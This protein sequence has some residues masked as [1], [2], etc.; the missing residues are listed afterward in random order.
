MARVGMLAEVVVESRSF[1]FHELLTMMG[2]D[3][4]GSLDIGAPI[5]MYPHTPSHWSWWRIDVGLDP[6]LPTWSERLSA[7]IERLDDDLVGRMAIADGLGCEVTL[8]AYQEVSPLDPKSHGLLVSRRAIARLA[9]AAAA[10]DIDQDG[11]PFWAL[12]AASG[13]ALAAGFGRLPARVT[14][15]LRGPA[16]AC[17]AVRS[18]SLGI[19]EITQVAGRAPDVGIDAADR[20]GRWLVAGLPQSL[21]VMDL[22]FDAELHP[23][24]DGLTTAIEQLDSELADRLAGLAARGCW[25]TAYVVQRMDGTDSYSQGI[26]FTHASLMWLARASATI[27]LD[28]R[29]TLPGVSR[30]TRWYHAHG[31]ELRR[32][33]I[34]HVPQAPV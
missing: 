30:L 9:T 27:T 19:G 2:R 17:I 11:A 22:E 31:R 28:Q 21:W 8:S 4:D 33:R 10:L 20:T 5:R 26:H 6:S 29:G 1:R 24:T 15:R 18:A 25:V 23:G 3:P 14:R 16:A 7:G 12:P 13:R 32:S 34:H